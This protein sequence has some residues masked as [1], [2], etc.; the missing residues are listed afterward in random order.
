LVLIPGAILWLRDRI[1]AAQL[2]RNR[3]AH[4][5]LGLH[6]YLLYA[7]ACVPA[8]QVYYPGFADH[9]FVGHAWVDRILLLLKA[10][11]RLVVVWQMLLGVLSVLFSIIAARQNAYDVYWI[12]SEMVD[13]QNGFS[14]I[15]PPM[16]GWQYMISVRWVIMFENPND[17]YG[18]I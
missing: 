18:G 10:N 12:E 7:P 5:V 8:W 4:L 3:Q 9:V 17:R 11:T 15:F 6:R 1:R 14:K 13:V 16:H 2:G